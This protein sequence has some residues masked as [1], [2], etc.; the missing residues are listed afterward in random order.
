ME[1]SAEQ[2]YEFAHQLGE[3]LVQRLTEHGLKAY[4]KHLTPTIE[5]DFYVDLSRMHQ[6]PALPWVGGVTAIIPSP[7]TV[8][9]LYDGIESYQFDMSD[10]NSINGLVAKAIELADPCRF[11][12]LGQRQPSR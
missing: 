8:V 11:N 5:I 12:A 4:W 1:H 3:E 9:E 10:P 7:V 2:W 6:R